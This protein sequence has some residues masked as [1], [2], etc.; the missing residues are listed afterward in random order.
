[1]MADH[2]LVGVRGHLVICSCV[3]E[4]KPPHGT[5]DHLDQ[6]CQCFFVQDLGAGPKVSHSV[7]FRR[8]A[9][10]AVH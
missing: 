1:M 9:R 6:V 3:R 4:S 5:R 8:V 2:D 7:D 10:Q